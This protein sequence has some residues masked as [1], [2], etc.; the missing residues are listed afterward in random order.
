M[1]KKY[2]Q[3]AKITAF[4]AVFIMKLYKQY[5]STYVSVFK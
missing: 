5:V 1:R 3:Y 2:V 4:E